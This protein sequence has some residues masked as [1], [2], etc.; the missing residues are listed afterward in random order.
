MRRM[1]NRG[2][3]IIVLL[4]GVAFMVAGAVVALVT[5]SMAMN[6]A[7]HFDFLEAIKVNLMGTVVGIILFVIGLLIV[8][9]GLRS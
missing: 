2:N 1:N 5:T 9:F 6:E 8:I 7:T 3:G 4:V